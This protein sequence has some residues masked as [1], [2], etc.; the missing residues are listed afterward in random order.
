[1]LNRPCFQVMR[2]SDHGGEGNKVMSPISFTNE[3]SRV[4]N[5]KA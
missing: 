5:V 3:P 2:G 4:K 1:M